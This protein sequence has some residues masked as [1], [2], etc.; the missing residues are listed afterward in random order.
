M[1]LSEDAKTELKEDD[2]FTMLLKSRAAFM[3]MAASE[4]FKVWQRWSK[5]Q[6]D[7][8]DHEMKYAATMEKREEARIYYIAFTK[9]NNIPAFLGE[10]LEEEVS[11]DVAV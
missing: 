8:W 11:S 1:N 2:A 5:K 9:F 3:E 6:I 10:L 7:A 4:G